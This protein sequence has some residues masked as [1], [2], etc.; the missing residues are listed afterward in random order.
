M[1]YSPSL[2]ESAAGALWVRARRRLAHEWAAGELFARFALSF[3]VRPTYRL[4]RPRLGGIE[5][6]ELTD[7]GPEYLLVY[8]EERWLPNHPGRKLDSAEPQAGKGLLSAPSGWFTRAGRSG[9]YNPVPG[10]AGNPC[11]VPWV[12]D[13]RTGY[14]YTRLQ[15]LGGY[16]EASAVPLSGAK[17][18]QLCEYLM[19]LVA[20]SMEPLQ[21][22]VLTRDAARGTCYASSSCVRVHTVAMTWASSPLPTSATWTPTASPAGDFLF[23]RLT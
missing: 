6:I 10:A 13:Y 19:D 9:P 8:I 1:G 7:T 20:R 23:R 22:L 12:R 3:R 15:L 2:P 16:T 11:E 17:Y 21:A 18:E 4:A 5:G 14:R